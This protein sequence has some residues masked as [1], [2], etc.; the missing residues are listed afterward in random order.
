MVYNQETYFLYHWYIFDAVKELL[1]NQNILQRCV[2]DFRPLYR[3]GQWIYNELYNEEWWERVQ[4]SLPR[5][6][7]VLSI[8]L[9][10]DAMTC[11][12]LGKTSEH[13]IYLTLGNLPSWD[14]NKPNA[15]VLLGYLP[16]LKAKT[17]SQKRSKGFQL[18]KRSLYQ[19]ALDILTCPLLDY[20]DDRFD[21][22]M[23]NGELW[24]YPFI[25]ALLGDL[26]ESA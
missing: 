17:I 1:S 24:C 4:R 16:Q 21:L 19:Y 7:K 5:E 9:Y 13:L 12:H 14:R 20:K 8:I 15:K 6:A 25:S 10:S 2:F 26:L 3:N 11:D 22:K 23:D 18:A